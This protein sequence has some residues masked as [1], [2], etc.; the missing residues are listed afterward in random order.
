MSRAK[1]CPS[2]AGRAAQQFA[3][4][5]LYK[6]PIF[7]T[8]VFLV[9]KKSLDSA[10]EIVETQFWFWH[11][12]K[13]D[14]NFRL[15]NNMLPHFWWPKCVRNAKICKVIHFNILCSKP[16]DKQIS[17][18]D[19]AWLWPISTFTINTVEYLSS[20]SNEISKKNLFIYVRR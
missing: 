9:A 12:P 2:S 4:L 11:Y 20:L 19:L 18:S 8:T 15:I 17:S 13:G 6:L 1:R 10:E 16:S 14:Y 3:L 5:V 7:P